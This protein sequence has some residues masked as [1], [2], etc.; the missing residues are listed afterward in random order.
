MKYTDI[1][2]AN[3][4]GQTHVYKNRHIEGNLSRTDSSVEEQSPIEGKSSRTDSSVEE[5]IRTEGQ[6]TFP[7]TIFL[8]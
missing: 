7:E 3:H 2:K 1:L 8:V 4:Q 6:K 5:Q